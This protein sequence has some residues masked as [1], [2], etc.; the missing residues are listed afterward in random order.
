MG[1][2]LQISESFFSRSLSALIKDLPDAKV[3]YLHTSPSSLCKSGQSWA[4]HCVQ[5]PVPTTSDKSALPYILEYPSHFFDAIVYQGVLVNSLDISRTVFEVK[6]VLKP[7]GIFL[8]DGIA[9]NL[10]TWL[11]HIV[12]EKILN[13]QP[14]GH[15]NWRLFLNQNE[16][17]RVLSAYNFGLFQVE[18]IA[19]SV[20][21]SSLIAGSGFLNA[22][23]ISIRPT[24]SQFYVLR[25]V[26]LGG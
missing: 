23:D 6:R 5:V 25:A 3:L 4:T 26:N 17:E 10:R 20:D 7:H 11:T 8:A 12:S 13:F 24:A 1:R 18:H 22:I 21:L 16:F 2:I 9:R 19:S 14:P 15:Y